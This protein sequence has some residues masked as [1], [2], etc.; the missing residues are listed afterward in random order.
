MSTGPGAAAGVPGAGQGRRVWMATFGCQMNMLDAELVAGDLARRGYRR[1]EAMD[2]ADVLLLQTCSVREHAEDKVWSLLG[3]ARL[4]K[5]QRPGLLVG[6]LGCMAQRAKDLIVRRAPHVDLVLGTSSFRTVV[7]DLEDLAERGGRILRTERTPPPERLP[8]ADRDVGARPD[9]FRAYVTVMRGC[10]HVCAYCIVP[11]TRGRETSRPL[12]EVLEE[13]RRLAGD[14]VREVTFLG[15]N[16]N[17]YGKDLGA[18]GLPA[19]LEQAAVVPG[20]ERLRFLTSNPFDMTEDMMRRMGAVPQVMPWLH[21]P[22]QSGHDEVL[23]RMKRTYTVAQYEEVVGWARRHVPG[24]EITSDFIV[25]FPG[26]T[27][28]EFAA[29]E[30]LVERIGFLQAYVFKYSVRPRTL[31]ARRLPDD[32]PEEAK[33]ERN[34]R[35]LEAQDRTAARRQAS[36]VGQRVEILVEGPSKTDPARVTGRDRYNRLV[37]AQGEAGRLAGRLVGVEVLESSAHCLVGRVL[38]GTAR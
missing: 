22:A 17:T 4:L 18:G 33:R 5:Q 16:I 3:R 28:G 13:V 38:E 25:G 35:L 26:E 12:P 23:R 30:A 9:P 20:I 8:D 31:A 34:T 27:E 29:T 37:H 15:Q 32:V 24:V 36:L 6:V 21:I 14:G 10:D 1:V 2:E 7:D 11:F 19:L